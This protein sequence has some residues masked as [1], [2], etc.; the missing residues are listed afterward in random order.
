VSGLASPSPGL[1]QT[2]MSTFPE[3]VREDPSATA[4]GIPH[5]ELRSVTKRFGGI[6]AL[7]NIDLQVEH[8]TVHAL[9]GENGAGKSTLGRIIC[10]AHLPDLGT[11]S[12]DGIEVQLISPRHA[13]A[14]GI[15]LIS[16][17]PTLVHQ[18]TV[19]ENVFLGQ[20]VGTLGFLRRRRELVSAFTSLTEQTGFDISAAARV[21]DLSI[22]QKQRVMVIRALARDAR[23]IVMDEPTSTLTSSEAAQLLTLVRH[24]RDSGR[25][26]VYISHSLREVL[27]IADIVTVLRDGR[28]IH[29]RSSREETT[30]SLASA[31]LG[32]ELL[33]GPPPRGAPEPDAPTVLSV[34][35]LSRGHEVLDVSF[36]IRA[37]EIVG[38]AGL[39]G[40][41]RS[42]MIRAVLG[43]DK[44]DSGTVELNGRQV[45]F[46]SPRQAW[47]AGVAYVPESRATEGLLL[48]RSLA[49]NI[50]LPHLSRTRRF[51]FIRRRDERRRVERLLTELDVRASGPEM[52]ASALSGGN[53]QKT[54][55]A[56]CL[57]RTPQL[58]IAD[59]P[60]RGVDVGARRAIYAIISDLA[61]RGLAVL[62][63]SSETEEVLGLAGRILVMRNGRIVRE[64]SGAT[65]TEEQVLQAALGFDA[66]A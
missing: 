61:Q 10:G 46:R 34:R 14:H 27:A 65:A 1:A 20:E 11:V 5:I 38:L 45:R 7:A 12:L 52:K 55:L 22:A 18:R 23:L 37:G 49:E 25:T 16:Q 63:V 44:P 2:T 43:A 30:R 15:A 28:L 54:L 58:L 64:L 39:I 42:E 31:M 32:R 29:T 62:L 59:E 3:A 19:L 57:Y 47:G 66:P 48:N 8:A 13:L 24:L 33:E 56:R 60:T 35:G 4:V 9:I 21:G 36:S 41:G 6:T 51:G 50:T 53:Q 40:S 26:I 17:E